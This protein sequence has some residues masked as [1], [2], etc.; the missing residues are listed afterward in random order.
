MIYDPVANFENHPLVV[1]GFG[2][3]AFICGFSRQ[4]IC[5]VCTSDAFVKCNCYEGQKKKKHLSDC[6]FFLCL[7][8]I[9]WFFGRHFLWSTIDNCKLLLLVFVSRFELNVHC[10]NSNLERTLKFSLSISGTEFSLWS[11]INKKSSLTS[12]YCNKWQFKPSSHF[13]FLTRSKKSHMWIERVFITREH[14]TCHSLYENSQD[15]WLFSFFCFH[16]RFFTY[17]NQP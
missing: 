6:L 10:W 7:T 1:F 17:G 13:Q 15:R 5:S 16:K 14:W 2:S 3:Q 11:F 12:T 8:H 4:N 9:L